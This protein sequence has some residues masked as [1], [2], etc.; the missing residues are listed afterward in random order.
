MRLGVSRYG[1][2]ADSS[3]ETSVITSS[4]KWW[5]AVLHS[6]AGHTRFSRLHVRAYTH[7]RMHIRTHSPTHITC[8]DVGGF[9]VSVSWLAVVRYVGGM[10]WY[11]W[12]VWAR[13]RDRRVWKGREGDTGNGGGGGG[14]G[15]GYDVESGGWGLESGI[16]ASRRGPMPARTFELTPPRYIAL[17][18][19]REGM[20][21]EGR[22]QRLS[23]RATLTF[24]I[25][26]PGATPMICL[27]WRR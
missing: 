23:P 27:R 21:R 15:G 7:A 25:H 16:D 14:S 26:A 4:L 13:R 24:R 18:P 11:K 20:R 1:R 8:E 10:G 2:I 22:L 5:R 17:P 3:A 9:L 19:L 12:S 6:R